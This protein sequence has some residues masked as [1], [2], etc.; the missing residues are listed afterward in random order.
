MTTQ[1]TTN[2]RRTPRKKQGWRTKPYAR[3][4]DRRLRACMTFLLSAPL[5]RLLSR[6]QGEEVRGGALLDLSLPR[7]NS[8][9]LAGRDFWLMADTPVSKGPLAPLVWHFGRDGP[10]HDA[11]LRELRTNLLNQVA[12]PCFLLCPPT[13]PTPEPT[14]ALGTIPCS[15]TRGQIVKHQRIRNIRERSG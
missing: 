2:S 8:F 9:K 14:Q 3:S 12:V 11:L 5:D 7:L 1:T 10:E 15:R 13:H 4:R 6:L